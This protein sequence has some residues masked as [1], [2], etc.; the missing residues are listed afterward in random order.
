MARRYLIFIFNIYAAQEFD[1]RF[2][3]STLELVLEIESIEISLFI[4]DTS[5]L[6]SRFVLF[7]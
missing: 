5:H 6:A 7:S 1:I 2:I 3:R 4:I